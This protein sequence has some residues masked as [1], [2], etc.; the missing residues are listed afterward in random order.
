MS[1]NS[2]INVLLSQLE[3]RIKEIPFGDSP[4]EL[5]EPIRYTMAMG[6]KRMRPILTLL[7]Y[8]LFA[9]DWQSAVDPAIAIEVFHNFTLLHDDIMD[10]APLR[11]GQ[12]TVHAKWNENVAILS[13]DVMLVRAYDLLLGIEPLILPEVIR[14]FNKTAAEVCEGQQWDMNFENMNQLKVDDYLEM[15][16]LKTA[17]LLGFSLWLGAFLAKAPKEEAEKMYLAGVNL[18]IGFQLMDDVLDVYADKEKF[19][20]Q[21]GGDIISNKKTF[22]L[23]KAKELASGETASDLEL[24]LNL[25]QFDP[26]KKVDAVTVIYN[27]LGIKELCHK[28]MDQYYQEAFKL[29]TEVRGDADQVKILENLISG[30]IAR[31]K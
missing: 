4:Y 11:R 8:R 21:V 12:A 25:K 23:I 16:R 19:G 15:I 26:A 17:V 22:L 24:W 30:L 29:I 1:P 31:E 2:D 10:K 14:R 28:E 3:N 9:K 18:G 7:A 13:G 20:K 27:Q 6:G 5:Y